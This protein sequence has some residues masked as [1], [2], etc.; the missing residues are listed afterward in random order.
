MTCIE[1]GARIKG[2]ARM[3]VPC[4]R[5]C[6]EGKAWVKVTCVKGRAW[7]KMICI[8]GRACDYQCLSLAKADQALD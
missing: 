2:M 4:N 7:I 6:I 8:K 1:G 5:A 3:E